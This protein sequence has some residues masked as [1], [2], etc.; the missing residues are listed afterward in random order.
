[1]QKQC[2][3]SYLVESLNL[4]ARDW[5][6][7]SKDAWIYGIIS[8]W[9]DASIKEISN[10]FKWS[11]E[12]VAKLKELNFQYT[13][14][15]NI[16]DSSSDLKAVFRGEF[17]FTEETTD[18]ETDEEIIVKKYVPWTTMKDIFKEMSKYVKTRQKEKYR[19]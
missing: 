2:V 19:P 15:Q 17:Y 14:M 11:D 6:S 7:N 18:M 1:M 4:D 5:S 12:S 9:D 10:K 3:L 8:G 16:G 13:S